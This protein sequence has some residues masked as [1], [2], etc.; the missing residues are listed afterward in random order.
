MET[1][2]VA[3]STDVMRRESVKEMFFSTGKSQ[4]QS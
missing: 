1:M 4:I 3:S 2:P